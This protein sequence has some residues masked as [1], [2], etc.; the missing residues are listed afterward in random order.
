M[1]PTAIVGT[2]G[3]QGQHSAAQKPKFGETLLLYTGLY[4]ALVF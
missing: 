3:T 1:R 4:R 2:A